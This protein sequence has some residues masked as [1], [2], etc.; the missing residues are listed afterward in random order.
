MC[1]DYIM[2]QSPMKL[3]VE[4]MQ[5]ANGPG[6]SIDVPDDEGELVVTYMLWA[7]RQPDYWSASRRENWSAC[8]TMNG[9]RAGNFDR[10]DTA[11]AAL[12]VLDNCPRKR[13]TTTAKKALAA[14]A[15]EW[16]ATRKDA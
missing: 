1:Y 8:W 2:T 7:P 5:P 3:T 15:A 4:P 10:G 11:A 16:A 14:A 6:W 9:G 12:A 13:E